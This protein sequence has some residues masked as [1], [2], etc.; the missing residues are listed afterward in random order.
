MIAG[1]LPAAFAPTWCAFAWQA[2][3]RLFA[4]S[5][6][7]ANACSSSAPLD[8]PGPIGPGRVVLVVGPSGAG[9]DTI[10]NEVRA[11]FADDVRFVFPRRIVTRAPS[12]IEDNE[13]VSAAKFELLVRHGAIALH[14]NA[15]GLRY[16]L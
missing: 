12:S 6:V 4:R 13:A 14:W 10:L 3:C 11:R 1:R 9:K 8:G 7:P 5:T 2:T 16:G 15:H